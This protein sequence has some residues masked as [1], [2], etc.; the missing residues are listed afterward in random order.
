MI[1]KSIKTYLGMINMKFRMLGF[2][3][4]KNG[5]EYG[6]RKLPSTVFVRS[7]QGMDTVMLFM[8]F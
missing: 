3:Q 6:V 5:G 4:W 1:S 2:W 8:F 7:N